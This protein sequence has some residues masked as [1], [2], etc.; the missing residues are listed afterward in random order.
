MKLQ[1]RNYAEGNFTNSAGSNVHR[2]AKAH[3][4]ARFYFMPKSPTQFYN[5]CLGKDKGDRYYMKARNLGLPKCPLP[6]FF[7][8]DVEELLM[9]I[10]DKCYYSTGNMQKDSARSFKVIEEPNRIKA[11]EIYINSYDTFNERQQEFLI[12]GELDFSKLKKVQIVCY[13]SFQAEMLRKELVGT[14]WMEVI[15]TNGNLY[16][17]CN[18]EIRYNDSDNSIRIS[19]NGYRNSFEFKVVYHNNNV[20]TIINKN[21][22]IR[23]RDNNI[24]IQ[25]SVELNKDVP[26]EVYFETKDPRI[27]S[28]LIYKNSVS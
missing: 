2:T 1:S 21:M 23:Q 3:R 10:P 9:T 27:E 16:D 7:V 24:F 18:K 20:P 25:D 15:S 19:T 6:V 22:V 8:F 13:D 11:R 26:F 12:E 5:E 17:H 14:P 4:F 28:W